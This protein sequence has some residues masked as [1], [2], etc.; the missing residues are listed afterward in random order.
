VGRAKDMIVKPISGPDANRVI[1]ALHYSGKVVKS[2]LHFGVFLDGKCGGAL[3]FG[4]PIDR[5]NLLT[6][7]RDTKFYNFLELNRMALADWLPRNGESRAIS[8]CLRFIRKHHSEIEWIMSFADGTQCGDGTIYR[9]SGFQLIG[10]KKNSTICKLSS[11]EVAARHGTSKKNFKGAKQLE[12]FQ[13]RYIYFLN[14]AARERLTVPVLPFSAIDEA[15]AGMY[16][17]K[18]RVRGVESAQTA[19]QPEGGGSTPTRTLQE[20]A[21][22][23]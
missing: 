6:L 16:R 17:S 22:N 20:E 14:P 10:L 4:P 23:D 9:A 15:G 19:D 13:L 5:R 21:A 1:K 8:C 3:Q 11:G 12:G 2:S 7:V 18:K